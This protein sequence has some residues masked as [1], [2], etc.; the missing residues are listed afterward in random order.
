[1][2]QGKQQDHHPG[3]WENQLWPVRGSAWKNSM[4]NHPRAK[5]SPRAGWLSRIT[6]SKFKIS[7]FLKSRKSSSGGR[8]PPWM[9]KVLL[10]E[11]KQEKEEYKRWK[12][13]QEKC[14]NSLNVHRWN[15]KNQSQSGV[16]IG[17]SKS[18]HEYIHNRKKTRENASLLLNGNWNLLTKDKEVTA[19]STYK[20]MKYSLSWMDSELDWKL[21]GSQG[22]GQ[23]HEIQTSLKASH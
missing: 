8:Q 15:C 10:T 7:P 16:G 13:G 22:C 3:L 14:W 18:I 1:M 17:N 21:S 5:R 12:Q 6:S 19:F 9:I 4:A 20:L 23:W 11:L 2:E